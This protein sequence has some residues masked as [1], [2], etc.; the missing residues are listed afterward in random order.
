[1]SGCNCVYATESGCCDNE[2]AVPQQVPT[3][4]LPQPRHMVQPCSSR[5]HMPLASI[6]KGL[7]NCTHVFFRCERVRKP[8]E[9]SYLGPFRVLSRN[10]KTYRILRGDTENVVSVDQVKAA[11][12]EAPPDLCQG[13]YGADPLRHAPLPSLPS[14]STSLSTTTLDPNSSS[15]TVIRTNRIG[16]RVHFPDR[17]ITQEF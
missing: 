1:M 13:Q 17:S 8:L 16:R 4:H 6:E 12:A 14:P 15:V 11:V 10:A 9:S 2:G 7:A 3:R 5:Y